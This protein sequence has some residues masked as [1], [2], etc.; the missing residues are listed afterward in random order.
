MTDTTKQ[1]ESKPR[2]RLEE[3]YFWSAPMSSID[4]QG[5]EKPSS[6]S[7]DK[8]ESMSFVTNSMSS[9]KKYE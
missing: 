5:F 1:T 6:L 8:R 7:G 4:P 2:A 9:K 3:A